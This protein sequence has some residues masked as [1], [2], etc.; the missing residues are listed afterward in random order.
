MK[1]YDCAV[2]PSPRRV[3]IYIAEKGLRIETVNV[4]LAKG[5]QM[6]EAYRAVN[7]NC[8]VPALELDDGSHLL[9]TAGI[10]S[11]LEALYPEPPLMGTTPEEKGR[12]ADAR[13]Y[14]EMNGMM[15]VAEALRN[16]TPRMRGRALPGPHDYE[17]IQAL[18]ERGKERIKNFLDE[19]D[20]MIGDKP[21]VAGDSYSIADIDLLV[22]V[23]FSGWLKMKLPE[24]AANA[25]RWY[26]SVSSRPSAKL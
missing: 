19:V 1:F 15:A 17:Q 13:W 9:F 23:D 2:A 7:P 8:T 5:E 20:A 12:I 11:Y 3:R 21:F 18:A 6:G 4:D 25:Q 16:S 26:A 10:C 22:M 24:D 14:I